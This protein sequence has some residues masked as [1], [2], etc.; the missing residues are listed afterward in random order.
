MSSD[1]PSPRRSFRTRLTWSLL[2]LAIALL[3][4]ASSAIYLGVR[5]ALFTN[6]DSSLLTLSRTEASSVEDSPGGRVHVHDAP[7]LFAGS[8]TPSEKFAQIRAADGRLLAKTANLPGADQLLT[9]TGL[10]A[11]ALAGTASFS[12]LHH[13]ARVLRGIYYPLPGGEGGAR[14][15][16]VAVPLEP[17]Q[18]SLNTLLLV[19]GATL[20]LGGGA[21]ALA[22][23]QVAQYLTRPL[24]LIADAAREIG[25][26]HLQ[27]RIPAVAVDS[28]LQA[29]ELAL[30]QMLSRLEQAFETQRQLGESQG[31]L[32]EAQR[33][34]IADASHE[35][36]SPLTNLRGTVEVALRRQRAPAEYQEVLS[37]ALAEI[38]R[39]SRLV[40][41]LLLLSRADAGRL[42]LELAPCALGS[43]AE[44]AVRL[45]AARA[46]AAGVHLVLEAPQPVTTTGDGDRLREVIDNLLDNAIRHGTRGSTVTVRVFSDMGTAC[47]EVID[48]GPGLSLEEQRQVF[49]RF[50]RADVSRDRHSGGLGLGLSIA[51][52]IVEAHGGSLMVTSAPGAGATFAMRVPGRSEAHSFIPLELS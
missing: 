36:R 23:Q 20:I 47:L 31:Q 44:A 25:L 21:A 24:E 45:C 9:A 32:V 51:R 49:D 3:T 2:S 42:R 29:V 27:T 43:L 34:F 1:L 22:A 6:L 16:V 48:Q 4:V 5:H 37:T 13:H 10:E 19:L 17:V 38:E 35:L 40:E 11:K 33:R 39:L 50:F 15:L 18:D 41:E 30:N 14:V 28:E 7:P 8:G 52:A 46:E 12:T 26:E